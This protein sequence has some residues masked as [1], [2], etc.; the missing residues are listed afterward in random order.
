MASLYPSLEDMKVD[1]MMRAQDMYTN[2]APTGKL[3][4]GVHNNYTGTTAFEKYLLA[5]PIVN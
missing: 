4:R 3:G 2:T 5:F 1:Q